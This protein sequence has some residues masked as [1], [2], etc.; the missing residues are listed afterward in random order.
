MKKIFVLLSFVLFITFMVS[1]NFSIIET[2][3]NTATITTE[4]SNDLISTDLTTVENSDLTSEA[5]TDDISYSLIQDM[6][7]Y[8]GIPSIGN[9]KI[10]VFAVDF[11]D[12]TSDQAGLSISEIETAFNG[13]SDDISYE[14][15]KSYYLKSS[16]GKLNISADVFGFYRAEQPAS[17]YENEYEKFWATDPITGEFLYD[18]DE[19]TYADSDLIYEVLLFY[20][21][22]IDYS[23]YDAN[24]D[25]F[26][27]GVYIIYSYPVSYG[28]DSDLWW[29][30]QDL[31]MY[32]GDVF[33]GVEPAKFV[34]AGSDFFN[35][36]IG[37]DIDARTV[38]HE[39]GHMLGLEDYYDYDTSDNYNS[40]GLGGIDMMDGTYGDH[41][42]FSKL[43][44]GWITPIIVEESESIDL[45]PFV[46][47]G[48]VI[49]L[50]NDWKGSIFDEYILISFYTPTELNQKD[51][52]SLFTIPGVIMYHIS[53]GID[54]GYNES[55]AYYSIFDN[56][57]TD[58]PHKLIDI[59][60]ADMNDAIDDYS[61][62]ENT[63]LFLPDDIL[64]GNVY[65]NYMW[66][67][68]TNL[69]FDVQVSFISNNLATINITD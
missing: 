23:E 47:S 28:G 21:D 22:V 11:S 48:D 60:E 35:S 69:G 30:Y 32:E 4:T 33:D 59:I 14:S 38:I 25:G 27:D 29:A 7:E 62:A 13:D 12:Y 36:T 37:E 9:S 55:Y 3:E 56:N 16:Y 52:Y 42:P 50:I 45:E 58:S 41:G 26:I 54:N 18:E 64:C 57:N 39:T 24:N 40:G 63:D 67:N 10:L 46:N 68:H 20:D 2:I 15:L 34:W 65:P 53:A 49:L 19:V 5:T 43:L 66:Y 44:L 51:K 61:Y 31:Y 17:Y 8:V 6:E 1:C